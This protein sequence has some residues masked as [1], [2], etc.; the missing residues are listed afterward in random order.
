MDAVGSRRAFVFLSVFEARRR[1]NLLSPCVQRWSVLYVLTSEHCSDTCS[2][3]KLSIRSSSGHPSEHPSAISPGTA[4]GRGSKGGK[5]GQIE[6]FWGR[7]R[8]IPQTISFGLISRLLQ[9]GFLCTLRFVLC[10]H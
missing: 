10:D 9:Q 5:S 3:C 4:F 8:G 7:Y 6:L 2:S 1:E